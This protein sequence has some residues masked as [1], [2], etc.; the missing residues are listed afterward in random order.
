MKHNEE[1]ARI[2]FNEVIQQGLQAQRIHRALSERRE[3]Q[4]HPRSF[5]IV[6]GLVTFNKRFSQLTM[7]FNR[8]WSV[9]GTRMFP[10]NN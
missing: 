3:E 5:V 8:V 4:V 7:L 9:I 10:T 1:L 6:Q 2:H